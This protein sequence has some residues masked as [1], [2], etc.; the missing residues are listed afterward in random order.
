MF[1]DVS[2]ELLRR[3]MYPP[4]TYGRRLLARTLQQVQ[5]DSGQKSCTILTRPEVWAVAGEQMTG[6]AEIQVVHLPSLEHNDLATLEQTLPATGIIMGLGGGHAMDTAKYIAWKRKLPL[7]L[8]PTIVSVDAAVTNTIAVRE[9]QRVRYIGFSVADAIP[10][11]LEVIA[12][13]PPDLNRAGVGD[14][15]SIHTALWDWE[16]TGDDYDPAVAA[17]AAAILSE[18]LHEQA[19]AIASCTDEALR[20]IMESYVNEN[21]LCLQVGNSRPEE[22]SE[23]FLG[24]NLEYLSGRSFV[25]GQLICLCTYAIARLQENQ[26]SQV[27]AL[28]ERTRCPWRLGELGISPECFI[29]ALLTLQEYASAESFV[30]SVINQRAITRTFAEQLACECNR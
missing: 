6:F 4:V 19:E 2:G 5:A 17:Q 1:E 26:P 20:S 15:L 23:H 13:A 7:I 25:H 10:V 9:K 18:E 11:D 30:P 14:L 22:G 21:R 27:H 24:Y 16:H 8:A 29:Q 12:Q 28:I 3:A